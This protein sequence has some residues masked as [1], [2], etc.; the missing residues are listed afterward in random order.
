MHR[1]VEGQT[2]I[3]SRSF[4]ER[5]Y[6]ESGR[7][8]RYSKGPSAAFLQSRKNAQES[9]HWQDA[10]I[11]SSHP[12]L[13]RR[14]IGNKTKFAILFMLFL[15]VAL[16]TSGGVIYWSGDYGE[17]QMKTGLDI[18]ACSSIPLVPGLYGLVKWIGMENQW[19]GYTEL[20][21]NFDSPLLY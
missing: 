15:G 9:Q 21:F 16:F 2:V 17:D 18:L 4:E 20:G 11:S 1:K 10:N 5:N 14:L 8:G 13:N 19:S 6:E 3:P 7:D 12:S